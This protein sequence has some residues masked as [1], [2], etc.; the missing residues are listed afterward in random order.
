MYIFIFLFFLTRQLHRMN[1]N[2]RLAI[3][4]QPL[5]NNMIYLLLFSFYI[6]LTWFFLVELHFQ[7]ISLFIICCIFFI[8][9]F[10]LIKFISTSLLFLGREFQVSATFLVMSWFNNSFYQSKFTWELLL[11]LLTLLLEK[12]KERWNRFFWC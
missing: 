7:L 12:E 3:K 1:Q 5:I 10:S 2:H 6:I 9:Q 11:Y 4:I 8:T